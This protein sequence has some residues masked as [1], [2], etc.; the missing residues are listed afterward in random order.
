MDDLVYILLFLGCCGLTV[1][2]IG[3][4]DRLMPRAS[5]GKPGPKGSTP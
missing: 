1:A 3:L 4:C 2:L 5:S